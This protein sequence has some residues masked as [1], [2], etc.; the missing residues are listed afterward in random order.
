MSASIKDIVVGRKTFFITPDTSLIPEDYLEEY[1]S[2][3]YECYFI[4]NDKILS[5]DKKIDILISL[6]KDIILF[7]NIDYNITGIDWPIFIKEILKKYENKV[8][9]GILY[10]KR[11]SKDEKAQLEQLYL[12]DLGCQCGCIQIEYKKANNFEIIQ[13]ILFANQ[14]QGRRKNIRAICT[15]ACTFSFKIDDSTFS[16]HLQD[17]SM[18][19]FSFVLP[20]N[21]LEIAD[22]EK[23]DDFQFSLRG[24]LFTSAA[25]LIMKRITE[26]GFLYV[27]AFVSD[28]G[29][30]GLDDRSKQLLTP[31]I[32]QLMEFNCKNLLEDV[33]YKHAKQNLSIEEIEN[34]YPH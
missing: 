23:I 34:I 2:L 33:F 7:F 11:Q 8:L 4:N 15:K 16:G 24:F 27:F 30:S 3:G 17:V 19:H 32:Y 12:M 5:L 10:N 25:V 20:A 29:G 26:K 13:K 22:Y 31:V 14:A 21:Q 18:S 6:F 1:F 9:I 28:T